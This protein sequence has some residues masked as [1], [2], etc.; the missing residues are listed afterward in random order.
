MPLGAH[1]V[2][3]SYELDHRLVI[4]RVGDG[5]DQFAIENGAPE[6]VS[7]APL[8]RPLL[9]YLTD[10]T[11][12]MLYEMLFERVAAARR[13]M[14][15]PIRCDGATRRRFVDLTIFAKATGGFAIATVVV[16]SE[17]RPPLALFARGARRRPESLL[18]CSWCN[19]VHVK[20][21]WMEV[22]DAVRLLR[23]FERDDQPQLEHGV[24]ESCRRFMLT[25]LAD[26]SKLPSP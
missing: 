18:I 13:P 4:T 7:P 11:T 23:L 1:V 14:T 10:A 6:L 24:C 3:C 2:S 16:R 19:R 8:G 5:W 22:D 15:V 20:A 9:M 12:V 25:M 26:D 21:Q 17:P